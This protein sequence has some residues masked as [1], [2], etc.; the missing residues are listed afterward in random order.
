MKGKVALRVHREDPQAVG[1]RKYLRS[2][3]FSLPLCRGPRSWNTQNTTS[4][5]S[6]EVTRI[7]A[8]FASTSVL[9][10]TPHLVPVVAKS[11]TSPGEPRRF[12]E[13]SAHTGHRYGQRGPGSGPEAGSLGSQAD[14]LPTV[15]PASIPQPKSIAVASQAGIYSHVCAQVRVCGYRARKSLLRTSVSLAG[16]SH[17]PR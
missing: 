9:D 14:N 7:N 2:R 15:S 4:A 1:S 16:N 17:A 13:G 12:C 8:T 6:Q 11:L 5:C 3:E 10:R